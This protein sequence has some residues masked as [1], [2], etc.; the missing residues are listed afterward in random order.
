MQQ[1]NMNQGQGPQPIHIDPSQTEAVTCGACKSELF[2]P[3]YMLRK[4][5]ALISPTGKEEVIQM[6][7]MVCGQ[8]GKPMMG[9]EPQ[10]DAGAPIGEKQADAQ[11][12]GDGSTI[13]TKG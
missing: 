4:V 5:S 8:C 12:E 10:A 3:M 1:N 13:I 11:S 2:L 9:E 6:P 7:V